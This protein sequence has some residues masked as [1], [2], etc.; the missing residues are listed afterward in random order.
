[1]L[2]LDLSKKT[3]VPITSLFNSTSSSYTNSSTQKCKN[4]VSILI[5]ALANLK[6]S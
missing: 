2:L 5:P 6:E 1:M 3:S 4:I